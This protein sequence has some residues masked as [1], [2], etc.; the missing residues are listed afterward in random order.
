MVLR[1]VQ[2]SEARGVLERDRRIARRAPLEGT[3]MRLES[4]ASRGVEQARTGTNT[5]STCPEYLSKYIRPT[6]VATG[7]VDRDS[8]LEAE[9]SSENKLVNRDCY[10][11]VVDPVKINLVRF[12]RVLVLVLIYLSY[13]SLLVFN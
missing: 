4:A 12:F 7:T 11:S 13:R 1:K 2:C 3:A 10:Q 5:A 8:W 6:C 9:V